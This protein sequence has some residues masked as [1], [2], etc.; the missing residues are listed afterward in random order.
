MPFRDRIA[1]RPGEV[2]R[3]GGTAAA[4]PDGEWLLEAVTGREAL[5]VLELDHRRVLEQRQN[6]DACGHYARPDVLRLTVDRT[7]QQTV[8][9]V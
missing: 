3:D 9:W 5:V 7:R 8:D 6:F 1:P 4:G 2:I